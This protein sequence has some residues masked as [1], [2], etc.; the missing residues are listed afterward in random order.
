MFAKNFEAEMNKSK[1][2]R[3]CIKHCIRSASSTSVFLY[4][5]VEALFCEKD[6]KLFRN[7]RWSKVAK[8]EE[9]QLWAESFMKDCVD[10]RLKQINLFSTLTGIISDNL[11]SGGIYAKEDMQQLSEKVI[12]RSTKKDNIVCSLRNL[13]DMISYIENVANDEFHSKNIVYKLTHL[14]TRIGELE[15]NHFCLMNF[16]RGKSEVEPEV[17]D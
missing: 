14:Q 16:Y 9:F 5:L 1:T 17:E 4:S 6:T 10:F 12:E 7:V 13:A 3:I 11:R 2:L 15:S 8:T